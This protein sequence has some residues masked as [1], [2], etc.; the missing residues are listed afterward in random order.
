[1]MRYGEF[2]C[3]SLAQLEVWQRE[4]P[5]P[6]QGPPYDEDN[7]VLIRK[8]V[9]QAVFTKEHWLLKSILEP[10]LWAPLDSLETMLEA[11]QYLGA[12]GPALRR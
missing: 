5:P 7:P 1:M 9:A 3:H 11:G 2:G 4:I 10:A 12:Q 6:D 8:N